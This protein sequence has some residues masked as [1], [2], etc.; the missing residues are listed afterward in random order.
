MSYSW[1]MLKDNIVNGETSLDFQRKQD[2]QNKYYKARGY[3]K[4]LN[5]KKYSDFIKIKH[6][7]YKSNLNKDGYIVSRKIKCSVSYM[8]VE[9]EYPYYFNDNEN[10]KHY[11]IWALKP[12]E[13]S[14]ILHVLGK[15][16]IEFIDWT[17]FVNTSAKQSIKDLWHCHIFLKMK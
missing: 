2:I 14:E 6:L 3:V 5:F 9:N 10:I 17:W 12:L 8:F 4:S 15:S 7:G 16:N 1:Q 13:Y 11:I